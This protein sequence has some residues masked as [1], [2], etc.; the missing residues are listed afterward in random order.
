M[1]VQHMIDQA[2]VRWPG[3]LIGVLLAGTYACASAPSQGPYSV[4]ARVEPVAPATP[5]TDA[6]V[7]PGLSMTQIS[8]GNGSKR[9]QQ[10][11]AVGQ[12]MRTV[13]KGLAQSYNMN[14]QLD[15]DVTG[16][17]TTKLE[18]VTLEEALASIVTPH[19][20]TYSL[21]DGVLRV[22]GARVQTRM[23]TLDYVAVSRFGSSNTVIQRR[24]GAVSTGG[25]ASFGGGSG[26][27]QISSV[28]VADLWEEIRVALEGLVFDAD[29]IAAASGTAPI[30]AQTQPQQG[31][32]VVPGG[33]STMGGQVQGGSRA[34]SRTSSS[35]RKLILNPVAGTIMVT[36][37]PAK[38]AEVAAFISAFEGSVQRQVL[39]EA[40]I[41]DVT[42]TRESQFGIDWQSVMRIGKL[43]A[44]I[45]QNNAPAAGG[46]TFTLSGGGTQV[47]AVLRALQAQGDVNVLLSPRISALNNQPAIFN[48]TTDE[49]VFN[50]TRQPILGPNGGTI[51]FNQQIVPQQISVG[52]VLHVVPQVGA[53]NTVT[54]NVRPHITNVARFESIKL[55]D[56]SEARA[57]VIDTRETDT[58]VRLRGGETVVIGG[59]MQNRISKERSGVP[60]LQNIPGIGKIFTSV[61]DV[62]EKA[63]L[64]IFITATIIA[65]QLPGGQ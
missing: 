25:Q 34:F 41:V 31:S 54:M 6:A 33:G 18:N 19:G 4:G 14:L 20:F 28:A 24:I 17:V 16:L 27:D 2:S 47:N 3:L 13:L 26:G 49:V 38:L 58:M 12:D 59:L 10:F 29:I 7:L 15:P 63:E 43:A 22:G 53:N 23:F 57:P 30:T 62:T 11:E 44:G 39:I 60:G 50:V 36:A 65:A 40:K 1:N 42:L 61:R 32:P 46:F 5:A 21:T 48:V 51:G 8:D 52:L 45:G 35:G 64:V 55:D 37:P 56:G 9:M